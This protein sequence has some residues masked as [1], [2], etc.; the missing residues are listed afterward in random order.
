MAKKR[1]ENSFSI[2]VVF[3]PILVENLSNIYAHM[4]STS[5]VVC[6]RHLREGKPKEENLLNHGMI[7][8]VS[9]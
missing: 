9:R 5:V 1:S 7:V 4:L 3:L 2:F 6:K 8:H